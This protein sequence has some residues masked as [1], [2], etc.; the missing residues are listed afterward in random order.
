LIQKYVEVMENFL[1]ES[2]LALVP[3]SD[4]ELE[5]EFALL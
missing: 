3:V 4:A 1:A 2:D 5:K